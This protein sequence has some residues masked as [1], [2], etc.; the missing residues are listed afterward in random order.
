MPSSSYSGQRPG[1]TYKDGVHG[2][3]Y[4]REAA[5]DSFC[6]T[7]P[8]GVEVGMPFQ[9]LVESTGRNMVVTCPPGAQAGHTIK[10]C[11]PM[12]QSV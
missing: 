12:V 3:G 11:P 1:Y 10:V 5:D 4:Y 2:M 6:V 8:E 7:V 9:V